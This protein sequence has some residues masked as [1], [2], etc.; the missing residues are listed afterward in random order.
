MCKKNCCRGVA[1]SDSLVENF[2]REVVVRLGCLAA[3]VPRR[4]W[5]SVGPAV[6]KGLLALCFDYRAIGT[7]VIQ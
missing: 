5:V 2:A 4:E 3:P 7:T 6:P 1:L